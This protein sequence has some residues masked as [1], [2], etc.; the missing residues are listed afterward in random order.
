MITGK[1]VPSDTII[2]IGGKDIIKA[3]TQRESV[4]NVTGGNKPARLKRILHAS[5]VEHS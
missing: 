2:G 4:V 3:K 1:T 5:D